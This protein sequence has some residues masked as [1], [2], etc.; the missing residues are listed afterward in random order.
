MSAT[1]PLQEALGE[2][3]STG[4][5]EDT[6]IILYS[7]RKSTGVICKP[8]ALYANSHVLKTVPYFNDRMFPLHSSTKGKVTNV[9][10][11]LS[12][13]FAEAELKDLWEPI[14]DRESADD[15]GYD[16]DSDLEEDQDVTRGQTFR[17]TFGALKATPPVVPQNGRTAKGKAIKIQDIAFITYVR[18]LETTSQG[19]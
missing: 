19:D 4:Q 8:K 15:Y 11:V 12:G 16:S 18:S 2:A 17:F 1:L 10:R 7:R 13:T 5:L 9:R 6:K 14:D 3:I